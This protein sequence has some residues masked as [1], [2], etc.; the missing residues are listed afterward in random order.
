MSNKCFFCFLYTLNSIFKKPQIYLQSYVRQEQTNGC[1]ATMGR[2]ILNPLRLQYVILRTKSQNR[3]DSCTYI[4]VH[5]LCDRNM[6]L[7]P[8]SNRHF[9]VTTYKVFMC[10]WSVA[11]ISQ[12]VYQVGRKVE[13]A[14]SCP[15]FLVSLGKLRLS[16]QVQF[17]AWHGIQRRIIWTSILAVLRMG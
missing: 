10:F 6:G 4:Y 9:T 12:H 7:L 5:G 1:N 2:N 15:L 16:D 17:I 11:S 13:F 8:A 3:C 14:R